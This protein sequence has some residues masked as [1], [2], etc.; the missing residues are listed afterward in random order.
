MNPSASLRT[1]LLL[2]SKSGTRRRMLDAAG[3]SFEVVDAP[4]DE[5]QAKAEVLASDPDGRTVADHLAEGKALSA[6]AAAD[7]LV[8]GADQVLET[9]SGEIFS[10][11][12]SVAE[13]RMQLRVLRGRTHFLHS[14]AV[15]VA[16]GRPC[17]RATETATLV[18]RKFGDSFLDDY[19]AR[20]YDEVRWNVGGYRIEGLGAQLFDRVDGSHF[21]ILGLPLLPLLAFLRSRGMIAT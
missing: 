9:D 1:G 15:V 2:A 4:F 16:N 20:E 18:M 19:L 3:V 17:W 10:K 14:A 11:A 12:A 6:A 7:A 21:A 5:E 13:M 8:L